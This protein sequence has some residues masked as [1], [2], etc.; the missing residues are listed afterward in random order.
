MNQILEQ[1]FYYSINY[2]Q[3]DWT[4]FI[5]LAEFTYI[6]IMHSSTKQT[7]LS[8]NYTHHPFQVQDI[9]SPAQED[10]AAHLTIIHDEFAY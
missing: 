6:N 4:D 10:L 1:Y 2:Q 3:N 9:G 8:S 7:P 5:P